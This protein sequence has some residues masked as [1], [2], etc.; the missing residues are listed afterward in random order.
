MKKSSRPTPRLPP[1]H[2]APPPALPLAPPIAPPATAPSPVQIRHP[3]PASST[4]AGTC[5]LRRHLQGRAERGAAAAGQA[6]RAGAQQQ[7]AKAGRQQGSGAAGLACK[8]D[9]TGV[10]AGREASAHGDRPDLV[11]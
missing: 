11:A 7:G 4:S 3:S 8:L 9:A 5:A 6:T 10:S 1:P 2:T